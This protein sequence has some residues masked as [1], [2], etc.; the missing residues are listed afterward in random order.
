M[1]KKL[2]LVAVVAAV[3][4]V[5]FKTTKLAGYARN[6][7]HSLRDWADDQVPVEKKIAAMRT[8]V[9]GLDRDVETVKDE[10][11]REIVDVR[12]LTTQ[13]GEFRAQ[14]ETEKKAVAQ[15]GA[16]LKDATEKVSVGRTVPAVSEAKERLQRDVNIVVKRQSQLA[17][18]ETTLGHRERI[19]ETL[20]KQL[21]GML[22]QK[23][24]LKAEIDAVEAEFKAVQLAQIES[25]HQRDDS[26]LAGVKE[27]LAALKKKMEVER[28][29]L[30]LSPRVHEDTT[31]ATAK[32]VEEILAPLTT[33]TKTAE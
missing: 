25:K 21:D 9:A 31:G 11:A 18:M 13:V 29:K 27:N 7:A 20:E 6:E 1:L 5:G 8:D 33:K 12:E 23:Q 2:L 30:K 10:L 17:T 3:A 14:L 4:W 15:R 32:S 19:R 24:E 16:D 26:R 22:K 28:E